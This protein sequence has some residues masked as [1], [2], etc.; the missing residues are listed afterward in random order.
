MRNQLIKS[1]VSAAA[2]VAALVSATPATAA[3]IV[4]FPLACTADS[5]TCSADGNYGTLSFAE[6]EEGDGVIV[7]ADL[8][9]GFTDS[10]HLAGISD[11]NGF[12]EEVE[13]L[14]ANPGNTSSNNSLPF[15]FVVDPGDSA[16]LAMFCFLTQGVGFTP[17][18]FLFKDALSQLSAAICKGT[19]GTN[20]GNSGNLPPG[21]P[22]DL[23]TVFAL[24]QDSGPED[25]FTPEDTQRFGDQQVTV[26]PEPASLVLTGS[27]LL[28]LLRS[29][30]RRRT[31]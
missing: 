17:R 8:G 10:I 20:G 24:T 21:F 31:L 1:A 16:N 6:G 9:N 28:A 13:S 19:S 25:D 7:T 18:N 2:L 26:V 11:L 14:F 23:T 4:T 3:T 15:D 22:E 27:G 12:I 5:E 30:R 29:R